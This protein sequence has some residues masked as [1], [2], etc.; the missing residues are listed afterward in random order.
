[1]RTWTLT[2]F[3]RNDIEKHGTCSEISLLSSTRKNK[4]FKVTQIDKGKSN[5]DYFN[6]YQ[7]LEL[8]R[9]VYRSHTGR[10]VLPLMEEDEGLF[11]LYL[12]DAGM[13]SYQSKISQADFF[14]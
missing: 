5:R 2:T 4:N 3:R 1:M 6:A 9:I 8:A 7:W 14:S 10:V 12:S 11:R 13:F